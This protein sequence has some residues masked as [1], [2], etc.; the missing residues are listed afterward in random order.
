[1]MYSHSVVTNHRRT[2]VVIGTT[3]AEISWVRFPSSARE[4]VLLARL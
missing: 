3:T 2:R 1:L 4:P